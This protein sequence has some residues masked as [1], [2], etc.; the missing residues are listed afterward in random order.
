[1]LQETNALEGILDI[2]L[3]LAPADSGVTTY[4]L[5]MIIVLLSGI[6]TAIARRWWTSPRQR[7]KRQLTRLLQ[8]HKNGIISTH[9]AVFGLAEI[10]RARLHCH[11]L[12][13]KVTVPVHLQSY[14]A[15]WCSFINV[16]DTARYSDSHIETP[17]FGRLASETRFWIRKW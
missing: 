5:I 9:D 16:L 12:S 4:T 2:A 13:D 15:R 10:L 14:Q 6:L 8:Q 1:M 11:Q 3:P 17:V 7:S